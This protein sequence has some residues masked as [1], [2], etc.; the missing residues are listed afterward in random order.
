MQTFNQHIQKSTRKK[1]SDKDFI[2]YKNEPIQATP[3]LSDDPKF[4]AEYKEAY[5][6]LRGLIERSKNSDEIKK[7]MLNQLDDSFY[8][9]AEKL[10]L[11]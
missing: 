6:R 2:S 8:K 1:F 11:L 5:L 3:E 4:R 10:N 7:E 9:A